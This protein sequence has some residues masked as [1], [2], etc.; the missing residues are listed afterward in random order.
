MAGGIAALMVPPTFQAEER[1]A[2]YTVRLESAL[3][4]V[5]EMLPTERRRRPPIR[6]FVFDHTAAFEAAGGVSSRTPR[7]AE[8]PEAGLPASM[9][10]GLALSRTNPIGRSVDVLLAP[11]LPDDGGAAAASLR[12]FD[13]SGQVA[14]SWVSDGMG[15]HAAGSW[16]GRDLKD[17]VTRLLPV[18]ATKDPT[19]MPSLLEEALSPKADQK[20]SAHVA[21]PL[22]GLLFERIASLWSESREGAQDWNGL[23]TDGAQ[24][25][26]IVRARQELTRE[27]ERAVASRDADPSEGAERQA[28][29]LAFGWA[30]AESDSPYASRG[31]ARAFAEAA[32]AG[33]SEVELQSTFAVLPARPRFARVRRAYD[34]APLEGDLGLAGGVSSARR[35]GLVSR[36]VPDLFLTPSGARF[37]ER[38]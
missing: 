8:A 6:V 2:E 10:G 32:G 33:V 7:A 18:G 25:G 30:F 24:E 12:A 35:S 13:R 20:L 17:W 9:G 26:L 19:W 34:F 28:S 5:E 38:V 16:W 31:A 22:R 37:T 4:R 1:L 14:A 15:L 21:L 29:G 27:L 11:D 3:A 23:W 36:I